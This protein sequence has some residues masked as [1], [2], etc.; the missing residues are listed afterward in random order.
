MADLNPPF[1]VIE[2]FRESACNARWS[3]RMALEQ[4]NPQTAAD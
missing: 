3:G 2:L 1:P 4:R